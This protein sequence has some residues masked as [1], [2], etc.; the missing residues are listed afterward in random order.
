MI[1][2]LFK[3]VLEQ[4]IKKTDSTKGILGCLEGNHVKGKRDTHLKR[5]VLTGVDKRI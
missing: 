2:P 1:S 3:E 5:Q 4:R